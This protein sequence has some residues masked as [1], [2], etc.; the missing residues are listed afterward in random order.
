VDLDSKEK[1]WSYISSLKIGD[2]I[3][4]SPS[5]WWIVKSKTNITK[6]LIYKIENTCWYGKPPTM[7]TIQ[8]HNGKVLSKSYLDFTYGT[9]Y[10]KQPRSYKKE[11]NDPN[12]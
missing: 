3:W 4:K 6:A 10:H 11:I 2:I 12:L 7:V 1:I 9:F 8:N 5:T